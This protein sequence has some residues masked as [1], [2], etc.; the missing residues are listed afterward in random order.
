MV[1]APNGLVAANGNG[2]HTPTPT[3]A[4]FD[5]VAD[6]IGVEM[7]VR[8][9]ADPNY[10]PRPKIFEE[11]SLKGKVAVVTGG[12]GGLGLE[13]A[14]GMCEAGAIVYAIDLPDTPSKDFEACAKLA[15]TFGTELLYDKADVTDPEAL[16]VI[17]S[18]I[19]EKHQR[20]DVLVAAAGI[21]GAAD[22]HPCTAYP[23]KE[24]RKV[25][26]I[27]TNGVFFSAQQA[28]RVMQETGTP[29][30]IIMIAS[31]SGT[32]TNRD[33]KWVAYNT[34][35]SAVLQMARS[36]ACELGPSKIRVNSLSPGHIYTKMTAALLDVK[37]EQG[38]KWADSNPLGRLG[39]V[40][41]LRG[42]IAW[43]A[44]D[45]STFCTGSDIIVSGGHHSW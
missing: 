42:V 20:L 9:A 8:A 3:V 30:S 6:P 38:K 31:M 35:K 5:R 44:S 21:L 7:A 45:A 25:M 41:E 33:H 4:D 39:A 17:F 34:S 36:M 22:G 26:D 37:P 40:H 16:Q 24:F 11:F 15:E 43:L 23:P 19:G 29:G 12:Y 2:V 1:A 28:A 10:V 27:N 13:M 18:R 14:L 32:I